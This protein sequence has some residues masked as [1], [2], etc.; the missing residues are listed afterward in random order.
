MHPVLVAMVKVVATEVV[1]V[2]ATVVM[3]D[4]AVTVVTGGI[5]E[6]EIMEET[7]GVEDTKHFIKDTFSLY[8]LPPFTTIVIC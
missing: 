2:V 5:V 3:E 6:E 7:S 1:R 4:R 8:L